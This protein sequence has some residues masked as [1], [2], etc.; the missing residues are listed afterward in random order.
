MNQK[1]NSR[2]LPRVTFVKRETYIINRISNRSVLH[3]GCAD[4][5]FTKSKFETGDLLHQKLADS[6]ERLIGID[7]DKRAVDWLSE[8]GVADLFVADAR[9]IKSLICTHDMNVDV[10]VAGEVLEHLTNPESFLVAIHEELRK[11]T[12]LLISV[13]NAFYIEGMIRVFFSYE[14][15]HPEHV[16]YYSYY[17]IKQLL[18][19]CGWAIKEIK[20]CLYEAKNFRTVLSQG[21]QL[22][23]L[24]LAPHMAP[25][26]VISATNRM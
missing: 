9:K 22:P 7:I 14:R 8:R 4:S 3:I 1:V 12:E 15:V 16:A 5:P 17:T 24:W 18:E 20:P 23:L 2:K 6:A 26:Y 25:G 21:L 19:R 13:P 11:D 10:V